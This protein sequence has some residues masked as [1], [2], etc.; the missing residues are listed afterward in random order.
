MS[1]YLYY[2]AAVLDTGLVICPKSPDGRHRFEP[3]KVNCDWCDFGAVIVGNEVLYVP[4]EKGLEYHNA[5]Q[6]NVLFYGGRGSAKST[7]GRWDAH[8]RALAFPGFKYAILRRKFP[9]LEKSHLLSV[10]HEIIKLGGHYNSTF[11]KVFYPN[12]S[13]GFFSHCATDE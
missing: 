7:T 4:T 1:N 13:V 8:L 2:P 12:G 11:H 10:Q 6:R 5:T 3:P 9:E